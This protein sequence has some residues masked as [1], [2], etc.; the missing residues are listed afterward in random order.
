MEWRDSSNSHSTDKSACRVCNRSHSRCDSWMESRKRL[1][2]E[3]QVR[4]YP[5][6]TSSIGST[7]DFWTTRCRAR[8][9]RGTCGSSSRW[10]F[11]ACKSRLWWTSARRHS[12]RTWCG[13]RSTPRRRRPPRWCRLWARAGSEWMSSDRGRLRC[14]CSSF[15]GWDATVVV[16]V[17]LGL[18]LVELVL[19]LVEMI[20]ARLCCPTY[21]RL[22]RLRRWRFLCRR[23]FRL[24]ETRLLLSMWQ[25]PFNRQI[26][27]FYL[28]FGRVISLQET[29]KIYF[30]QVLFQFVFLT[31]WVFFDPSYVF[32][33]TS[34]FFNL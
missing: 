34:V 17:G 23:V 31:K 7:R 4:G 21:S 29:T 8:P 24:L 12:G 14:M 30:I 2:V 22:E 16:A 25:R 33:L 10:E 28:Y 5:E 1:A 20:L 19:G 27:Y 3:C 11:R 9:W 6:S 18:E 15:G 26:D 32:H 13:S